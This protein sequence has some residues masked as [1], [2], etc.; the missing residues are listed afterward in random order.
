MEERK[1]VLRIFKPVGREEEET[2]QKIGGKEVKGFCLMERKKG[3]K[4][5]KCGKVWEGKWRC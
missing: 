2:Q 1:E 4:R 3:E 5:R